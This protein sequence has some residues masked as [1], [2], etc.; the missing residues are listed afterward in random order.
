[1]SKIKSKL[2]IKNLSLKNRII[3]PPMATRKADINGKISDDLLNWYDEKSKG[4]YFSL[5][6][7]EHSFVNSTGKA[8]NNQISIASDNDIYGLEKLV[9]IIHKNGSYVVAQISHSG[10]RGLLGTNNIAPSAINSSDSI[11]KGKLWIAEKGLSKSQI[12]DLVNDFANAALRA[13]KAGF[14]A[15]EI[16]S[17][18]GY[19]LN[20]FYSPITNHRTDEYGGDVMGRIKIHLEIIDAIRKKVGED[21]PIML[22]FGALDYLEGGSSKEDALVAASAFEK[23]GVDILDI[24]GGLYGYTVKG[25]ENIAGYF[26]DASEI[27]KKIV[28]TPIILTGGIK[29]INDAEKLLKEEKADLI[30][31]GRAVFKDSKWIENAINS[32]D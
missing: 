23:A 22:R 20:Q 14:D 6:I 3:M 15:V 13:K 27:I 19:L 12:S 4:G 2:T 17:A 31:I 10:A 25:R 5:I 32:I 7:I 8:N 1:M 28:S 16:H 9:D 18:H 24:S 30:G 29:D 21:F 26:S 11:C